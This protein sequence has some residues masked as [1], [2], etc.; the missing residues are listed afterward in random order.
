[1]LTTS[2]VVQIINHK[3][4]MDEGGTFYNMSPALAGIYFIPNPTYP[5]QAIS[6]LGYPPGDV[7][8]QAADEDSA[9]GGEH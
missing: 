2:A 4:E 3:Y 6:Q 5:Y 8:H 1:V 7:A 9:G